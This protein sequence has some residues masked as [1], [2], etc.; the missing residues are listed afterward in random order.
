MEV[1]DT[2]MTIPR[3]VNTSTT[4]TSTKG[5]HLEPVITVPFPAVRLGLLDSFFAFAHD[6]SAFPREHPVV[7][8][9]V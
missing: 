6:F 5:Q 4:A 7:S 9:N 2:P 8:H 1:P 3:K